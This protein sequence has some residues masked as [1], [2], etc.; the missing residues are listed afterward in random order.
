MICGDGKGTSVLSMLCRYVLSLLARL[1]LELACRWCSCV[2]QDDA[3][4][5]VAVGR[6]RSELGAVALIVASSVS[7]GL[8]LS[9]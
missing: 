2:D 9:V 4:R 8:G 5:D 1:L 3:G 7:S 6:V